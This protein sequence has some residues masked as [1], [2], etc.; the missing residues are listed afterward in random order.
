VARFIQLR[1]VRKKPRRR[2]VAALCV[3]SVA[4]LGLSLTSGTSLASRYTVASENSDATVHDTVR[5]LVDTVPSVSPLPSVSGYAAMG[6]TPQGRPMTYGTPGNGNPRT[7]DC[8]ISTNTNPQSA[9]D[10]APVGAVV[11]VKPGDYSDT[12][13]TINKAITVRANGVVKIK[14]A[15]LSGHNAV[16]DGFTVVGGTLDNPKRA[17]SYT[18]TGHKIINNLIKGRGIHYAI[19]CS[20]GYSGCGDNITIAG[21]TITQVHNFGIFIW[22]GHNDIVERNNIYDLWQDTD[23]DDV[24]AMRGWGTGHV[25]RDN[26]IHDLNVNKGV[27]EPHNDCFQNY[28]SSKDTSIQSSNVTIEDNYCLRVSGQCLIM[29]NEHRPTSDVRDYVYRGNVCESYGGQNIELGSVTGEVIEDNMLNG[30]VDGVVIT[31]HN[32]VGGLDTT[33]VKVRDNILVAAGGRFVRDE[34]SPGANGYRGNIGVTDPA[35]SQRWQDFE[36]HPERPV[37]AANPADFIYYNTYARAA[38]VVC[39][40][41][42]SLTT[43]TT[44][45]PTINCHQRL[46]DVTDE[47]SVRSDS[48]RQEHGDEPHPR[49]GGPGR[50]RSQTKPLR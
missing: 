4:F 27:G 10:S 3:L 40:G 41:L 22:G 47:F 33:K 17:I 43:P 15:K 39:A 11:C 30:G 13:L 19:S 45:K 26:Y 34:P 7:D 28:Q 25:I 48:A 50:T 16:L 21:N 23:I 14:A 35:L 49:P 36:G 38:R 20:G 5:R 12:T 42:G 29:Q 9:V 46:P 6:I 18:G 1:A 2:L 44:I 31:L 24:D 32:T 8:T 37:P